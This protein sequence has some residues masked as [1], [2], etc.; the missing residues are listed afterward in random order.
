M[1]VARRTIKGA[2]YW[3]IDRRFRGPTGEERFRRVAQ[4]QTKPAA[5]AEERRIIDYWNE[6][7][8]VQPLL[9]VVAKAEPEVEPNGLTWEDML[10]HYRAVELPKRKPSTRNGYEQLLEGPGFRRWAGVPV[11]AITKPE[12]I[13]WDTTLVQTGVSDSTRR[14]HHVV[15]RAV[16]RTA[17]EGELIAEVPP[18]P[19]LPRVGEVPIVPV[20][21]QDLLAILTEGA[22]GK[23]KYCQMKAVRAAQFAFAVAAYAGLRAGE[24]RALRRRDVN[25]EHRLLQVRAART[26]GEETT[27][28]SGKSRKIPIAGPLYD[29]L[30]PR[31][32]GLE[33]DDYL[34]VMGDGEPWSDQGMLA[35]LQRACGRLRLSKA[36][37]HGLRHYFATTVIKVTDVVTLK[38]LLGHGSLAVTQRY[39]HYDSDR[40]RDAMS[41]FEP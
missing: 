34:C 32:R 18:L 5:E 41:V 1:P 26:V 27:P 29:L 31:C 17:L 28:K 14:N 20:A 21:A 10:K 11:A 3:V 25:L 33:P 35:A 36:K 24:V 16:F 19:K 40:A 8:T 12:I 39:V 9:T 13:K 23:V 7:G 30:E 15:L 2:K 4:V 38:E 6:H 22:D 37:Y